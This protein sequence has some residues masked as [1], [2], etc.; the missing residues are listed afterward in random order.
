MSKQITTS[1]SNKKI[2]AL[3]KDIKRENLILQPDF[4]RLIQG[5]FLAHCLPRLPY[6]KCELYRHIPLGP[7]RH[8]RRHTHG[9]QHCQPSRMEC[10]RTYQFRDVLQQDSYHEGSQQA[11]RQ[12]PQDRRAEESA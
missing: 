2:S 8:H 6:R 9:Q 10:R 4:Q 1:P 3:Y 12:H 11:L 7:R 5:S